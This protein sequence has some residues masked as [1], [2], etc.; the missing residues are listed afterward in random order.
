MLPAMSPQILRP[1][2]LGRF[3]PPPM[4]MLSALAGA[5]TACSKYQLTPYFSLPVRLTS[6]TCASMCTCIGI[7]SSFSTTSRIERQACGVE[8]TSRVLVSSTAD[9]PTLSP[10]T[11]RVTLPLPDVR[12]DNCRLPLPRPPP[13]LP[14]ELLLPRLS[15][16][17]PRL[18]PK[19]PP[20]RL[21]LSLP[22]KPP[23]PPP[24]NWLICEPGISE[25]LESPRLPP[26]APNTSARRSARSLALM[27]LSS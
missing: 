18:P 24:F 1:A 19:L 12:G 11:S 14:E 22:L 27:Y 5:F 17:L 4:P 21:L 7:T 13:L 25:A 10:C 2:A 9:T 15:L 23:R 16:L 26:P 6:A 20:P 8:R 3:A